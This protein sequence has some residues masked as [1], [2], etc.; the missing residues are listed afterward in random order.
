M[1]NLSSMVVQ[2][3]FYTWFV[4]ENPSAE[5]GYIAFHK[6]KPWSV[7]QLKDFDNCCCGYNTKIRELKDGLNALRVSFVHSNCTCVCSQICRPPNPGEPASRDICLASQVTF[8]GVIELWQTVV[9]PLREN[10]VWHDLK[11]VK[12]NVQDVVWNFWNSIPLK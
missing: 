11:C 3:Y 1:C 4:K 2:L 10:V 7:K 12:V 8:T 5:I 6:L 9:C